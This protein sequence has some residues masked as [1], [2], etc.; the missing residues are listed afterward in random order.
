M[1]ELGLPER[2]FETGFEPSGRKRIN[3]YFNLRW[4]EVVKAA[5]SDSQQELLAE[6]QFRLLMLMG[7]HT[8]SVMFAHQLLSRQLVTKKLYELWWLFAGKPICYGIGEFALVTGL[9]CGTPPTPTV[10]AQRMGKG[11]KKAK[12]KLKQLGGD[13]VVWQSLFGD[14]E[15]ITP[16]WI[17]CRLAQKDKY[18][19][20]DTRLRLSLLLLVEGILCPTSG[21][22]QIRP[23]IVE[24]VGDIGQFMDY[25]WGRESFLLTVSSGKIRLPEQLAQDTLA[26]QGFAH[27]MVLVTVCSCPQIIVEPRLGEDLVNDELPIED[28]VDAVCSRTVKINVVTV[29]NLELIGQ[30]KCH[31]FPHTSLTIP[32]L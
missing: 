7:S 9:N 31:H 5:L 32:S 28:I 22:T 20:E 15:T 3:N 23:E 18:K 19:D 6:S 14:V 10:G 1:E 24:M 29:Q 30:V 4:I 12:S 25:P 11:K 27:A 16:E 17:I 21:S 8:F 26:I 13:G 2:L